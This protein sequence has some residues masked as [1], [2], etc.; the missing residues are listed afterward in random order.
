VIFAAAI[1]TAGCAASS[2]VIVIPP[3]TTTPTP[4]APPTPSAQPKFAYTANELTADLSGYSIDPTTG[5]LTPLA[6]FPIAS[7]TN[8]IFITHDPANKFAIVA[9]IASDKINVY[10]INGT[11]GMLTPVPPFAYATGREPRSITIDP[12]GHFV[13]VANSYTDNISAFVMSIT[14]VL[15]PVPGSPFPPGGSLS[16]SDACCVVTDPSGKFLF[17]QD[18]T[19]VYAYTINAITGALTFANAVTIP[20]NVNQ[21]RNGLAVDPAGA[22]L[23]SVAA[24]PA[25]FQALTINATSGAIALGPTSPMALPNGSYTISLDPTGR[26]AYTVENSQYLVAYSVSNGVMTS[27]HSSS[28]A[29][30]GSSQL[31]IDPSGSFVYALQTSTLNNVTG[32][33]INPTG[34]LSALPSSPTPSGGWPF[35]MTITSQ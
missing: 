22:F 33:R 28:S 29:A 18:T 35:S 14:G 12:T 13:Y 8:P 24:G 17:L 31:A 19:N 32:F 4:P 2:A 5:A 34:T 16:G 10:A 3:V 26:F 9:D 7:G 25:Q 27:L 6:G 1:G 11:T 30:L 23:Y 15:T 21:I 20:S